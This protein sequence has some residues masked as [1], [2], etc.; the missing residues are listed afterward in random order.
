VRDPSGPPRECP[1]HPKGD[2]SGRT[3]DCGEMI[4]PD[5]RAH[6]SKGHPRT[7]ARPRQGAGREIGSTGGLLNRPTKDVLEITLKRGDERVAV[8]AGDGA[9]G[10][11]ADSLCQTLGNSRSARARRLIAL[12]LRGNLARLRDA[13]S[14]G[15]GLSGGRPRTWWCGAFPLECCPAVSY[16]P[17][18]SR[19]QYHRRCGS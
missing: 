11:V 2:G 12:L 15:C 18:L 1:A 3:R 4:D 9:R 6:G 14:G 7:T 5:G 19:V 13:G 17:T 10:A 16:S 8:D